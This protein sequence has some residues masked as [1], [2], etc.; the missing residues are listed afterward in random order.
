M[1]NVLILAQKLGLRQPV[2]IQAP[3]AGGITTPELVAAVSNSGGL[4]SFATGYLTPEAARLG[5]KK[6]KQLTDKPFAVNLLITDPDA[7]HSPPLTHFEPYLQMLNKFEA[8]LKLPPTQSVLAMPKD[9]TND[10]VD[11]VLQENVPI[12]SFAFGVLPEHLIKKLKEAGVYLIGTATSL[13]E[14]K[15]LENVGIDAIV[16]QGVE[17]GGH[18]GGFK[19]PTRHA[20]VG[21]MAL[22]PRIA[23]SVKCPVIAAGGIMNGR[24]IAAAVVLGA[25]G[26]Q[27]GTS[28]IA[29]KESGANSIYKKELRKLSL[30]NYDNTT[31]TS[32][33]SG[34]PARGVNTQFIRD[35]EE[36]I[37]VYPPYPMANSLSSAVRKKAAEQNSAQFMSLWSGQGGP[38]IR[39]DLMAG[40]LMM[41]FR[42]ELAMCLSHLQEIENK[43]APGEKNAKLKSKL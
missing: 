29:T 8:E 32:A 7:E 39:G 15:V 24:G 30:I 13:E 41:Q 27:M 20:A 9:Y 6:I 26:V 16:A 18:R 14:A 22:L 3:M 33:Y 4:G 34:K 42:A 28:F 12:I 10:I 25:A 19:T 11:I 5:I 23:D 37:T 40:E 43:S 17:A 21:L 38:L 2:I 36:N 1:N 31:I 35:M